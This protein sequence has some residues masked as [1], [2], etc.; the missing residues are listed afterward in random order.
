MLHGLI[1]G[2]LATVVK[3]AATACKSGAK[4]A[5]HYFVFALSTNRRGPGKLGPIRGGE[6]ANGLKRV[7]S[8]CKLISTN[9][10]LG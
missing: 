1:K 8:V 2:H 10:L 3:S 4:V 7:N 6:G 5:E 9:V